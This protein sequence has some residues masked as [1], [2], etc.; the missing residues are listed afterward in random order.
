MSELLNA[1]PRERFTV[2]ND[3]KAEW[4]L[5]KI[6]RI[7]ADQK[8]ET[9]ELARQMQFYQDQMDL[10]AKQADD[11]VS[12]F[13]SMLIPY[14]AERMDGGFTKSTKTQTSYKLPTGKLV[15]KK[16]EP[17]YERANEVLLA[18]VKENRPDCVKVTEAPDWAKLKKDLTVNGVTAV[19][20]DG[21]IVPGV[22]VFER[23]DKF[24]VEVN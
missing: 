10:I 23:E 11:D 12:F 22:T 21:E 24:V 4:V 16:Q 19:T 8:K 15:L 13:E 18:W 20:K 2:D 7:R 14:F 1:E 3:M 9:D 5:S 6:R 17:E